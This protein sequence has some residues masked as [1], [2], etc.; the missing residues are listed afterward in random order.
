MKIVHISDTHLGYMG[1]GL[2]KMVSVPWL[3]NV[4]VRQ[5]AADIIAAFTTAVDRIITIIQPE[6]V[7][8]SGDVF[9]TARPTA[10]IVDL[11]MTQ[12]RRLSDAGIQVVIIEGNHSYPRDRSY[13]SILRLLAHIPKVTV[14]Y[15]EVV[16][17]RV[18][19]VLLHA[20]PYRAVLRGQ[21]PVPEDIDP[22]ASNVLIAH[23]VADGD[24]FFQ[25][26]RT[27]VDLPIQEVAD[28]FTYVAL[29]HCHRF[30]QVSGTQQAFYAGSP[31]MITWRDFRPCHS[32]GFNVVTIVDGDVRV[33]REMLPTRP[34][35][36]YGL[37]DASGLSAAE[38]LTF[39]DRQTQAL[40][41]DDSYCL[42]ILENLDPLTRRELPLRSVEE[43]FASG[44]GRMISL[45]AR[46][47][48][49]EAIR[50]GLVDGGSLDVRLAQ[51]VQDLDLDE[52]IA[53][54]VQVLALDLLKVAFERVAVDDV[55]G[56]SPEERL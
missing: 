44:A 30:A 39:L 50:E 10:Y 2:G 6:L 23:G 53:S 35:H 37:D 54:E 36:P 31:A 43:I 27:A 14:V 13:G 22:A 16:R 4:L 34:M 17:I 56:A 38:V 41:P 51:L 19:N 25:A 3:P 48:H 33:Q 20:V 1:Q 29:G 15:D 18:K 55:H 24:V 52:A 40:K 11:A 12:F 5:Q 49:W 45:R 28:W 47:Q 26:G 9:D 7:I 32:F 42:I 46:E 21:G 8:H